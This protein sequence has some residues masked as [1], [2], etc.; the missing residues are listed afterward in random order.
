MLALLAG[1]VTANSF[2]VQQA[3]AL[4]AL[5]KDQ[6]VHLSADFLTHDE[7][8]QTV[9]ATGSVVVESAPR[10]LTA[11]K[12][13]YFL[14]TDTV[15]AEGDVSIL[16]PTGD[17]YF[18]DRVE[19]TDDMRNGFAEGL[20]ALL[21]DGST[22][23]GKTAQ[24]KD[25]S[26]N[27][28][29]DAAYTP[30]DVCE[31][32]PDPLWQIRAQNVTMDEEKETVFYKNAWFEFLDVPF[33]FTP[34]FSHPDPGVKQKSGLLRPSAGYNDT[35]GGFVKTAYYWAIAPDQDLTFHLHGFGRANPMGA[36]NY[37]RRFERGEFNF[38][39]SF[40]KSDR[41]KNVGGV[42]ILQENRNRAHIFT[43]GAV[44][45]NNKW[46][47]GF[48]LQRTTDEQYLRLYD[49]SGD[50]LLTS[51]IFAERFSGR[52]YSR[53][54]F[55]HYQDIR[56]RTNIE[57]PD[58]LPWVENYFVG[59]PRDLFGGR[60]DGQFSLV[61]LS[62]GDG[63]Q[64]MQRA[65]GRG[66]WKARNISPQGVVSDLSLG[67]RADYYN[68]QDSGAATTDADASRVTPRIH[69]VS[70]YPLV[71][72]MHSA[73]IVL[74]PTV[75]LTYGRSY[76]SDA[77]V[78]PN[79]DSRDLQLDVSNLF[80]EN[81][82]AGIDGQ[83]EGL[84]AA[85]GIGAGLYTHGGNLVHAFLGQSYQINGNNNFAFGSGL[86]TD[87]SDYVAAL[88]LAW[89]NPLQLAYRTQVEAD[90]FNPRRH[91]LDVTTAFSKYK[92]SARYLF[93]EV[94]S[95]TNITDTREEIRVGADARPNK[96][97]RMAA[98]T[99]YDLAD[100]AEL[101][102]ASLNMTYSDECFFFSALGERNLVDQSSGESEYR[103]LLR[104]GFKN[105]GEF[106]IPAFSYDERTE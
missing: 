80:D 49:F 61:G 92:L 77:A 24:R 84:H 48:Q 32:D 67:V 45:L 34:F 17:V 15:M 35:L 33:F 10:I 16:E 14:Q 73:Q 96:N 55:V 60:W 51:E 98:S 104:L 74:E 90:N 72:N 62:R 47:A 46:R 64:D 23:W 44:H 29:T 70:T 91:E 40:T 85:A 36:V 78:I 56:P 13:V 102:K 57:Q 93:A 69:M 87:N 94:V 9:T 3:R 75:S 100:G 59:E 5:K 38:E 12:V 79:E 101:R 30:C 8:A 39:S 1:F 37:R 63:S 106:E 25:G 103:V 71:S 19:L 18:A 27:T 68:V 11:D 31:E 28:L 54:S 53:A 83:E 26:V 82:F 43:D 99:L 20:R 105:I 4:P 58:V 88:R 89:G 52:N 50:R 81:R 95:G 42:D 6:P 41:I 86:E 76:S 66:G 21:V 2:Y 7:E 22:L 97:W 65:S